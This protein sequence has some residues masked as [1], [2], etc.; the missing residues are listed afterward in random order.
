MTRA[1]LELWA[2]DAEVELIF[3]DGYDDAILGVGQRFNSFF[4]VY[5]QTKVIEALMKAGQMDEEEALEYFGFNVVGGWVGE[6]TP[7]FVVRP[8]H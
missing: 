8:E 3:Y 1:D 2:E 5:D 7:C 6:A 4:V